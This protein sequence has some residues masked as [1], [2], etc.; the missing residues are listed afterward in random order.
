LQA[1]FCPPDRPEFVARLVDGVSL[2][3]EAQGRARK[4]LRLTVKLMAREVRWLWITDP[5]SSLDHARDTTLRLVEEACRAGVICYWAAAPDIEWCNLEARVQTYEVTRV[6]TERG[7]GSLELVPR[8]TR[9]PSDFDVVHY[10]TD[11]PVD[12]AYLHPLQLIDMDL[13]RRAREGQRVELINPAAVLF[14]RCEKLLGCMAELAAPTVASS[15]WDVLEAFGEAEGQTVAKPLHQ[16]QSKGVVL[17][18]WCCRSVRGRNRELLSALT[19]G[20]TRPVVLQRY[21]RGVAQGETRL[22]LVDG[23]L[24]ACVCKLPEPG[25]FKIDMDKGGTLLPHTLSVVERQRLPALRAV[26]SCYGIRIAAV[27]LIDGYVTDFN[28]TSPG[29]LPLMESVLDR[30]LAASVIDALLHKR[31]PVEQPM[32]RVA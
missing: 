12:L 15:R 26:L 31:G 25:T 21:L 27:D 6:A 20:F 5:W 2:R 10:R 30:N 4:A 16:A 8:G 14:Q 11:P 1:G 22:W 28:F 17:L 13:E 18:D 24:L 23:E 7:P 29:L 3:L 19:R 9:R 32:G